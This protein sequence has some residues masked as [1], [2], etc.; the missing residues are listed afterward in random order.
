MTDPQCCAAM[1]ETARRLGLRIDARGAMDA[2]L[3]REDAPTPYQR[4]R[5]GYCPFCGTRL[6]NVTEPASDLLGFLHS[7][8][9]GNN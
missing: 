7:I 6:A 3:H 5:I 8:T 1:K 9:H 4:V 2:V